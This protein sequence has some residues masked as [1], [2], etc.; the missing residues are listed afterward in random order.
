M[1]EEEP[2]GARQAET[3][4][5]IQVDEASTDLIPLLGAD[6]L[7]IAHASALKPSIRSRRAARRWRRS[8]LNADGLRGHYGRDGQGGRSGYRLLSEYTSAQ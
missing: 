5:E 4:E 7:N 1:S 6:H 8:I 3:G 2:H